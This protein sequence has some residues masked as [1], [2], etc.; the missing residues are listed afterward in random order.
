MPEAETYFSLPDALK[1]IHKVSHKVA[2]ENQAAVLDYIQ[3]IA[4]EALKEANQPVT[5]YG[6]VGSPPPKCPQCGP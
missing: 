5:P 4:I 6:E 2:A 1:R 3:F